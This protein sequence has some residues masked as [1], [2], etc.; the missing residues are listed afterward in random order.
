[1]KYEDLSESDRYAYNLLH[2]VMGEEGRKV[3]KGN[4]VVLTE[5]GKQNLGEKYI[6]GEVASNPR[7]FLH[8]ISVRPAGRKTAGNYWSGFWR[9]KDYKL[10]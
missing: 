5:W 10:T 2:W 9:R 1:M 4:K 6:E 8:H 3:K 7:G